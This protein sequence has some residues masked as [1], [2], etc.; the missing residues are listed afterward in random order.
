MH[1]EQGATAAGEPVGHRLARDHAQPD[2]RQPQHHR[3]PEFNVPDPGCALVPAVHCRRLPSPRP[4]D[5]AGLPGSATAKM[6]ALLWQSLRRQR[7]LLETVRGD[8]PDLSRRVADAVQQKRRRRVAGG[9]TKGPSTAE[10]APRGEVAVMVAVQ[11]CWSTVR[12]I[13]PL[14]ADSPTL[15]EHRIGWLIL[16]LLGAIVR[17]GAAGNGLWRGVGA[18]VARH[19]R[20]DQAGWCGVSGWIIRPSR[21]TWTRQ[22]TELRRH[23][24]PDHGR[25]PAHGQS[26]PLPLPVVLVLMAPARILLGVHYPSDVAGAALGATVGAIVDSVGGAGQVPKE[27]SSMSEDVH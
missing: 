7:Q 1:K 25:G 21:S 23:T 10:R 16:A 3:R 15:G 9:K 26:H 14:R 27:M 20:A 17:H 6:F 22:S 2:R 19:R 12:G 11:S 13:R 8:A 24:P 4:T 5:A 18:F